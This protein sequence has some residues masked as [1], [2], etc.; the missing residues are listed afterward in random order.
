[1]LFKRVLKIKEL[2]LELGLIKKDHASDFA[3]LE[4]R[5]SAEL[6]EA[7][8][9]LKVEFEKKLNDQYLLYKDGLIKLQ[10]DNQ[11]IATE[12]N[13][14]VANVKAQLAQ[15]YY[16]KMQDALKELSLEGSAQSKFVEELSLKMFDKAL[17][18][19]MAAHLISTIES[20]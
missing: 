15:D 9:L 2:E 10:M 18:K 16:S 7:M 3:H 20:K 1:M 13:V 6:K 19:P 4:Q 12:N 17:E 8:A 14:N 5:K 11:K